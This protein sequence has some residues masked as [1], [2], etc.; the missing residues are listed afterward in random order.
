MKKSLIAAVLMGAFM[1]PGMALAQ[2]TATAAA[3]ELVVG[4]TVYDPQ[5]GEVGTI[6]KLVGGNVVLSTGKNSATLAS[7]AFVKGPNGPVIG[8]TREQLDAAVEQV[9]AKAD[10]AMAAALVPGAEVRST[11]GV[12]VGSVE[13]IEG[14]NVF[15]K[16]TEGAITL[17][18]EHLMA[19]DNGLK[20]FMTA[21]QFRAAVAAA[22][23]ASAA[24]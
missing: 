14:E 13:K 8:M 11:D 1:T 7:S 5:G 4:G 24:S 15:V 19:D 10:A 20:L 16:L 3:P 21:E 12:V 9:A 17:K 23:E 18:K 6:E 22:K 2:D